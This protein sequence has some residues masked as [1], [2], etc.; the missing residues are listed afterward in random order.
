MGKLG[1]QVKTLGYP[2][3]NTHYKRAQIL[4]RKSMH[5]HFSQSFLCYC[6]LFPYLNTSRLKQ[7]SSF[8]RISARQYS[9]SAVTAGA[10]ECES[11][12]FPSHRSSISSWFSN[13]SS[14]PF[15]PATPSRPT[16]MFG[17]HRPL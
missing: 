1:R 13:S 2:K 5:S 4:R 11:I 6:D 7:Q 15:L 16:G 10:A 14:V 3:W 9:P 17:E 8:Q 12:F